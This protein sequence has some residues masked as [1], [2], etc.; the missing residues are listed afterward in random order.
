[1]DCYGGGP[2]SNLA[3]TEFQSVR[4]GVLLRMHVAFH[5]TLSSARYDKNKIEWAVEIK[6]STSGVYSHIYST[7]KETRKF[8]ILKLIKVKCVEFKKY[9]LHVKLTVYYTVSFTCNTYF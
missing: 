4:N 1:M 3:G 9:V 7:A 5:F 8:V 2:G 6:Y